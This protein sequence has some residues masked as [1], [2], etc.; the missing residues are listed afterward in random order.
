MDELS[1]ACFDLPRVKAAIRSVPVSRARDVADRALALDSAEAVRELLR[2]ELDPLLPDY[3][4]GGGDD[5]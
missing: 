3:V 1:V 2:T 4:R 5:S